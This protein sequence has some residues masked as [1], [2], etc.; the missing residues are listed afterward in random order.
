MY[1]ALFC[2]LALLLSTAL[3]AHP[4]PV[5]K[6]Q[7]Q[8][9]YPGSIVVTPGG[10][11]PIDFPRSG[12]SLLGWLPLG[13]FGSQTSGADSWGYVSPS[14][15]EYA[16]IG[17]SDALSV[18]EITD[19]GQPTIIQ[20]FAAVSSLWRDVKVYQD[21]AY[22]VSE[23]GDGIVIL[24]LS[25]IDAGVVTL[26]GNV[27]T[28]GTSATHNVAIDEVS[29]YLYRIGGSSHGLRMYSLANKSNPVHVGNWDARYVHDAQIVTYTSGPNNG[30]Q[31][32][33]CCAEDG[34]GG[35]NAG[36]DIVDVTNK[37]NPVVLASYGYSNPHFSHQGW[38][39]PDRQFFYL[40]DELDESNSGTP[41]TTRIINV[42]NIN[43]PFQVG[44]FTNGSSAIDH[45]LYT[46]G[47]DV[48][49]ANYRSGLRVYDATNPTSPTESAFFDTYPENDSPS[50]NGLWNTYPYFPSGTVIGSDL[51]K[52]LFVWR[53]GDPQLSFTFPGG[54]NAQIDPAG[55]S[56]TVQISEQTVGDLALG[57]ERLHVDTGSGFSPVA[58]TSLGGGMYSANFPAVTCGDEVQFYFSAESTNG[59]TWT[60]PYAA[61]TFRYGATAAFGETILSTS[62][63]ETP[64]GFTVGASGDDATTG[65]WTRV[66]PVGTL[67]QPEDDHTDPGSFCWVTGQ[68]SQGGGLGD[69]DVDGGKTTLVS[70]VIDL[71]SGDAQ[72]SYWRWYSN[73]AGGSPGADILEVEVSNNGSNWVSAEVVG[74]SGSE[75][76]GG[77]FKHSFTVSDF[78]TPNATIQVRFIAS[79]EGSGSIVEAAIDDFQ[80]SRLDCTPP[81]ASPIAYGT[82]ELGSTG[83][84]GTTSWTG[85]PSVASGNFTIQ[86][87]GFTP[88][89]FAVMFLG[90]GQGSNPTPGFTVLVSGVLSRTIF[91]TDGNGEASLPIAIAPAQIGF[92]RAFQ[93]VA[94]DPG[95]GG[96]VQGGNG[97]QA[98]FCP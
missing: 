14:G 70:N 90:T 20:T 2:I 69:D 4:D 17:M 30:K 86:A 38:L 77:W 24:N 46:L 42:S 63:F 8:A 27:T 76:V 34:A 25:Q 31:I 83:N 7:R 23:G 67:A 22:Y 75:T 3:F 50:F 81:C 10:T 35:G 79:D 56:V 58:L 44:T 36:L 47:T 72:I 84:T 48:L 62:D 71:S 13:D 5:F 97:V 78:V 98:T 33:F 54:L 53:L 87:S 74:P 73:V 55:D 93:C 65:I 37:N 85:T 12:I 28:G 92:T 89:A 15:R 45:N 32:A 6:T 39:S 64:A 40:N 80:V 29:G 11:L 43:S 59:V 68:G 21:H 49:E 96:N 91:F 60:E 61:P 57:T 52:G 9:P 82:G 26:V 94:R 66:N 95:F 41:T 16:M 88:N 1:R 51:E 19:P 18:I